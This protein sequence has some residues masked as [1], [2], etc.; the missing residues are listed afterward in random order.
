MRIDLHIHTSPLSACSYI[1]P[2]ELVCEARRLSLDGICLTEHQVI[3]NLDEVDQL[4]RE[5]GIKIFRGNEFTTNQ[6]DVLVFGFYEDIKELM[7]IQELREEVQKAGGY[8]IAAHPFRG[9]KTFG[10]GQ[11]QMTVQQAGKRKVFEF[12]DAVEIGNGKLSEDENAMARKVAEDLGLPGT[13]GSDAHRVDEIATWVTVF[14]KDIE[15]EIQL[16]EEL[17]AARFRAEDR[18]EVNEFGSGNAEVGKKDH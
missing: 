3:W 8:M 4:A 2:I 11:L 13:G 14:E 1:D 17:H 7:I 6:G 18:R 12:V 16:V 10:I 5:G 15:N 9:F